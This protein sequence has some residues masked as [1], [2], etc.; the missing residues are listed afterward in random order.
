MSRDRDHMENHTYFQLSI[1]FEKKNEKKNEMFK[2]HVFL[3]SI[4]RSFPTFA[5]TKN[6]ELKK[7][8]ENEYFLVI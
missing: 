7:I 3:K 2:I 4:K 8:K 1:V 6:N 5:K